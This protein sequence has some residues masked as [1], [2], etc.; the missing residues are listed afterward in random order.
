MQSLRT[1]TDAPNASMVFDATGRVF[2]EALAVVS[3]LF[4]REGLDGSVSDRRLGHHFV[5]AVGS[6]VLGARRSDDRPPKRATMRQ[7]RT[8]AESIRSLSP[9]EPSRSV[10]PMFEPTRLDLAT[11]IVENGR[12]VFRILRRAG[13]DATTAEDAAQQVFLTASRKLGIIA[14]GKERAFLYGTAMNVAADLRRRA[15]K[16]SETELTPEQIDELVSEPSSSPDQALEKQR[17]RALLDEVLAAMPEP[18]RHLF[19]LSEIEEMTA[20][21]VAA[22]LDIPLGTV[23]SRLARARHVFDEC[24]ARIQARRAFRRPT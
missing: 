3:S 5:A 20:P 7:S 4:D 12:F 13:L 8:N 14:A 15:L 2:T 10:E 1:W 19:V 21:E 18:L 17:A 24:L 11:L 9:T 6:F 23:A 16:R 22:C